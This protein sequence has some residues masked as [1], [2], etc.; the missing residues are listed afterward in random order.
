MEGLSS[1][2]TSIVHWRHPVFVSGGEEEVVEELQ[3]VVGSRE[4]Y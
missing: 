4:G 3:T 2:I 1:A